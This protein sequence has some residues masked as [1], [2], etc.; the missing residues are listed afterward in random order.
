MA[1]RT[2]DDI[3]AGF[4]DSKER[5]NEV[6]NQ[7]TDTVNEDANLANLNSTS[8]TS[9]WRLWAYVS[10]VCYWIHE[11]L[12]N[13]FKAEVDIKVAAAIPMTAAWYVEQLK[14]FQYG[15][16]LMFDDFAPKYAVV[17]ESKQIIVQAAVV[18][19][20]LG[21]LLVKVAKSNGSG[22][23]QA[24]NTLEVQAVESYVDDIKAAGT[25]TQVQSLAADQIKVNAEIH[26]NPTFV[27]GAVQSDVE[28]AITEYLLYLPF[29]AEILCS[30]LTDVVQAVKG[31]DDVKIN[32]LEVEQGG[33][34]VKIHRQYIALAGYAEISPN[35]PLIETLSYIPNV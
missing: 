28:A 3:N 22:G 32:S 16:D 17:D 31:V 9:I 27:A 29:N 12:W 10:A 18:Q 11:Y 5:I 4:L 33:V 19:A 14:G 2:I 35:A 15:D 1:V 7:L 25:Q 8:M 23:L 34:F 13:E 30:K 6:V 21:I 24:L 26:Y 20:M